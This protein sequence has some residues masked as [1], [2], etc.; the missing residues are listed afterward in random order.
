MHHAIS[1]IK[2]CYC[3][4]LLFK[5]FVAQCFVLANIMNLVEIS[6]RKWCNFSIKSKIQCLFVNSLI[7]ILMQN[8]KLWLFNP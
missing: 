6:F 7:Y 2:M 8:C 3:K 4:V 1:R 5:L